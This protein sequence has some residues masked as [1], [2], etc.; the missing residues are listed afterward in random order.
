MQ[1]WWDNSKPLVILKRGLKASIIFNRGPV[2]FFI[3][4][5]WSVSYEGKFEFPKRG[6]AASDSVERP[7][8]RGSTIKGPHISRVYFT[9]RYQEV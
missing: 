2:S 6:Q 7:M 1:S 8:I 5:Y 3:L 9:Y 4:R